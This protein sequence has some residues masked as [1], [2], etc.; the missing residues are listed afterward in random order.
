[1]GTGQIASNDCLINSICAGVMVRRSCRE[2]PCMVSD[3]IRRPDAAAVADVRAYRG[4]TAM[5]AVAAISV[6]YTPA[7]MLLLRQLAGSTRT[8]CAAQSAV[9]WVS[10]LWR[11]FPDA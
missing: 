11:R 4:C 9:K 8:D 1:M 5:Q 6:C 10:G 3:G 2:G 7:P